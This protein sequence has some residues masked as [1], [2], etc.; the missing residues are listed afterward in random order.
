MVRKTKGVELQIIAVLN[1]TKTPLSPSDIT[2]KI[3]GDDNPKLQIYY[4]T[5][6]L[7]RHHLKKLNEQYIVAKETYK[8][9]YIYSLQEKKPKKLKKQ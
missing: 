9:G 4:Q 5:V 8:T 7:V 2:K 3:L 6:G 1:N